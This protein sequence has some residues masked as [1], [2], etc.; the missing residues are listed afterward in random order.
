MATESMANTELT[1]VVTWS[2]NLSGRREIP[3]VTTD[4]TGTAGFVFDF[5]NRKATINIV[6]RSLQD[7]Q[8]IELR[9]RRAAHDASGPVLITVYDS[10][11][12]PFNGTLTKTFP[13][14][15]FKE[16]ATVILN[17]RAIVTVC[18]K[19]HPDGEITGRVEMH[20]SYH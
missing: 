1:S 17:G 18:T 20:K 8:K 19:S 4:A 5:P 6:T 16:L 3:S 15:R 2:A 7:V 11:D 13:A 9:M 12:G 10:K 14:T